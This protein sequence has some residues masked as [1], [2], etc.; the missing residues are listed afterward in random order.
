[1]G[2]AVTRPQ[3][4]LRIVAFEPGKAGFVLKL[5]K[6]KKTPA[7]EQ[8]K[9]I[10]IRHEGQAY[11]KGVKVGWVIKRV[12]LGEDWQGIDKDSRTLT[13]SATITELLKAAATS[14]NKYRVE[15]VL[16]EKD[17]K[18]RAR[19][20]LSIPTGSRMKKMLAEEFE[21]AER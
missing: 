16:P 5:G 10:Q 14:G 20:S 4:S 18:H 21:E 6:G 8:L 11:W 12:K 3:D 13:F 7:K 15:F 1:M 19:R 2:D 17:A 9:V